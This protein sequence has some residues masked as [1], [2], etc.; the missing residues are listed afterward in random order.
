MAAEVGLSAATI[1]AYAREG[2]IPRSVTPGGQYR[3]DIDEVK[4]VL[5]PQILAVST[6]LVDLS[7][8]TAPVVDELTAHRVNEP[9]VFAKRAARIRGHQ[10]AQSAKE[11]KEVSASAG[12]DALGEMV[13]TSNGFAVV[14]LKRVAESA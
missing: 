5:F 10:A 11:S 1:Q 9:S 12:R 4:D 6:R 3:Y 8:A 13:Q 7:S 2:R 14:V